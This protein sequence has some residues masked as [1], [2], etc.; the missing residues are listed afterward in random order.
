[1][2]IR[3]AFAAVAKNQKVVGIHGGSGKQPVIQEDWPSL[4]SGPAPSSGTNS[5]SIALSKPVISSIVTK[6]DGKMDRGKTAA[7]VE[8]VTAST[9]PDTEDKTLQLTRKLP[10]DNW[11][12]ITADTNGKKEPNGRLLSGS[13][14]AGDEKEEGEVS[15]SEDEET[16]VETVKGILTPPETPTLTRTDKQ[17]MS[18]NGSLCSSEYSVEN[19]LD[20]ELAAAGGRKGKNG[21]KTKQKWVPLSLPETPSA[22]SRS[23]RD[24]NSVEKELDKENKENSNQHNPSYRYKGKIP[25]NN[26]KEG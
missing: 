12:S 18:E 5:P 21:K 25:L 16:T 22:K 26:N 7:N 23:R 10:E 2:P 20:S 11:P 13:S 24:R 1:V 15:D 4:P 14:P 3:R 9:M 8:S 17:K 6:E 19:E